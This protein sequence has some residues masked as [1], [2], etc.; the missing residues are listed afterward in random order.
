M[1]DLDRA[2]EAAMKAWAPL[3]EIPWVDLSEVSKD[4]W[5]KVAAAVLA[6]QQEVTTPT[7]GRLGGQR[8]GGMATAREARDLVLPKVGSQRHRVLQAF[9]TYDAIGLTDVELAAATDLPA[10]SVRPRRVELVDA[11][12]VCDTGQRRRHNGRRH[13]V[14]GLTPAA[15]ETSA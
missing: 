7:D 3:R 9:H 6:S 15:K 13:V 5:R 10:N 11:G 14:W 4:I 1:T 8:Q 2:A 12:W